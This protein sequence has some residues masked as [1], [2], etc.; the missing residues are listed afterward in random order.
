MYVRPRLQLKR[1]HDP[2]SKLFQA[3]APRDLCSLR[4]DE[5]TPLAHLVGIL[6]A[7]RACV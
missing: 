2:V 6:L 3:N 7:T 1:F 5:R 4:I